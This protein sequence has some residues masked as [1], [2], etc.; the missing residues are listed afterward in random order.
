MNAY[1]L[2]AESRSCKA[3]ANYAEREQCQLRVNIYIR[4]T[5]IRAAG[6]VIGQHPALSEVYK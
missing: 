3:I 2:M 6:V 5:I 4:L 1:N